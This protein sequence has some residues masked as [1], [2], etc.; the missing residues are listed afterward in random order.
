MTSSNNKDEDVEVDDFNHLCGV[1]G[2]I[3]HYDSIII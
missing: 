1:A 2:D 3:S